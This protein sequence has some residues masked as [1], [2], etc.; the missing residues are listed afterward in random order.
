LVSSI[1]AT[2]LLKSGGALAPAGTRR[3]VQKPFALGT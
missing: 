2:L 1:V 3:E